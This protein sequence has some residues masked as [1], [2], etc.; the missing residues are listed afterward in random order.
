MGLLGERLVT[1][2]TPVILLTCMNFE[3]CPQVTWIT[4]SLATKITLV[5][6]HAHM[7]HKVNVEFGRRD[8][9]LGAHG[10]LPLPFLAVA[11]PVAAAVALA[12]EMAMDMAGQMS[13]ELRIGI[14]LLATVT[15]VHIWVFRNTNLLSIIP[16][17]IE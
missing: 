9:S 7:T 1:Q 17:I 3:V 16:A 10:T 2:S 5:G 8:K 11:R 14:A 15:E 6:L 12:R 4:K 13:F